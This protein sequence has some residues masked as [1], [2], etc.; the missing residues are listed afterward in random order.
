MASLAGMRVDSQSMSDF[1]AMEPSASTSVQSASQTPSEF[2]ESPISQNE[3]SGK[4][5]TASLPSSPVKGHLE[6]ID[7]DPERQAV[8]GYN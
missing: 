7:V 5:R 4:S 6:P 1:R 2:T 8:I 3:E